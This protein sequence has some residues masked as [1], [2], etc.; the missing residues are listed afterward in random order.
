MSKKYD[1][2]KEQIEEKMKEFM[3]EKSQEE[4]VVIYTGYDKVKDEYYMD[5]YMEGS[6]DEREIISKKKAN[7]M[8]VGTFMTMGRDEFDRYSVFFDAYE[9]RDELEE[10]IKHSI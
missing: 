3:L 7:N 2:P 5:Y 4:G 8:E 6:F 9:L 10:I 1:I